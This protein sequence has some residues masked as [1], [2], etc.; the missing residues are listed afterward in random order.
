MAVT[1][2]LLLLLLLLIMLL[3]IMLFRR[4]RVV[5][6]VVVGGVAADTV[7]NFVRSLPAAAPD[8]GVD[9]VVAEGTVRCCVESAHHSVDEPDEYYFVI[10]LGK[11]LLGLLHMRSGLIL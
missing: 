9:H 6:G 7:I 8:D 1:P 11:Q 5:A 4:G 10:A 2:S 3:L